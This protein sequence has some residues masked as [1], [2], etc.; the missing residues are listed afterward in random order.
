M[1]VVNVGVVSSGVILHCYGS[2]QAYFDPVDGK[3]GKW[4]GSS[5]KVF[6]VPSCTACFTCVI[7]STREQFP[8]VR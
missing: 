3:R 4:P 7:C 5:L 6:F 2:D 8:E 1:T